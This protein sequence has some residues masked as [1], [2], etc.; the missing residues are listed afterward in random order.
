LCCKV[1]FRGEFHI[2]HWGLIFLWRFVNSRSRVFSIV[3]VNNLWLLADSTHVDVEGLG[4]LLGLLSLLLVLPLVDDLEHA[5]LVLLSQLTVDGPG[6]LRVGH[7]DLVQD[8]LSQD[9]LVDREL[10]EFKVIE[11]DQLSLLDLVVVL[12]VV[13]LLKE[14]M[15]ENLEG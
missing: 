1:K 4:W 6:L 11:V 15:L 2:F 9:I 7:D 8:Q 5:S 13:E 14:R 3:G 12:G 10:L